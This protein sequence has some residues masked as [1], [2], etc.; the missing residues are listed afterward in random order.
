MSLPIKQSIPLLLFVVAF[1]TTITLG[2]GLMQAIKQLNTRQSLKLINPVAANN[3]QQP[4]EG[5]I[6]KIL[7]AEQVS[8]AEFRWKNPTRAPELLSNAQG[9]IMTAPQG[10]TA[11]TNQ[12]LQT[13]MEET[14]SVFIDDGY[15]LSTINSSEVF[16]ISTTIRQG[17]EKDKQ[18]CLIEINL[19]TFNKV[20]SILCA[21]S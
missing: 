4:P 16:D 9:I 15:T 14:S 12:M 7:K 1:I 20:V 13:F 8:D 2:S 5:D 3:N 18:K 19:K 11:I 6:R 10:T 21:D 17:F